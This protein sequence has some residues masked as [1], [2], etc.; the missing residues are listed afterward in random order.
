MGPRRG[1]RSPAHRKL[2]GKKGKKKGDANSQQ[3]EPAPKPKLPEPSDIVQI[4]LVASQQVKRSHQRWFHYFFLNEFITFL[5]V[6]WLCTC[7]Y[8]L[9]LSPVYRVGFVILGAF[10]FINVMFGLV[11]C[12]SF[13]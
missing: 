1:K 10:S 6:L 2:M 9:E 3:A 4:D 11:V 5:V 7:Q 13:V 8:P 12:L